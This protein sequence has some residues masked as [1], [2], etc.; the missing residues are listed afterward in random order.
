[1]SNEHTQDCEFHPPDHGATERTRDRRSADADGGQPADRGQATRDRRRNSR[2]ALKAALFLANAAEDGPNG[3]VSVLGLG[4]T[5]CGTPTP[6]AALII[7][8]EVPWGET[9]VEHSLAITLVDT[10]GHGVL[11]GQDPAGQPAPLQ[12]TM[13]F[14]AGR[15]AGV[16]HGMS[17]EQVKAITIGPGMPLAPGSVYEWRLSIDGEPLASRSFLVRR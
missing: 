2:F 8:L 1:M 17:I 13:T 5:V 14:E 10:D 12:I 16:P 3:L 6:P 9:N 11:L 15:P 7:A 4:W